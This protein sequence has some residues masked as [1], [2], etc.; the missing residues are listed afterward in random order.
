MTF[1]VG[2]AFSRMLDSL[3][4]LGVSLRTRRFL[5]G[6]A[7]PQLA[8]GCH[9]AK[10]A[11]VRSDILILVKTMFSYGRILAPNGCGV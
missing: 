1:L 5:P 2:T 6:E 10:K 11:A 3:L 9:A 8:G 4:Y 7:I